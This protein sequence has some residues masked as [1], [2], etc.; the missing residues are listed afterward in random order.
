MKPIPLPITRRRFTV[1]RDDHGVPH[2]EAPT[3]LDALYGLGYMH[4]TDRGTQLLFSRTL[5]NGCGAEEI[6]DTPELLETDRFFRRVGLHLNL[7]REVRCLNDRVFQQIT[8]YCEGVTDGLRNSG[9]SLPM[10]A[11]GYQPQ[12]WNQQAVLLI[13]KLLSFGGLAISQMQNERLIIELVHAGANE[14]TIR[15]LLSP[16]FDNVDFDVLRQIKMSNQLSDDALEVL[17]DLPRLAGSNAWA[18]SP[19]RSATGSALLAADPHLEVNRLPGIWYEAVLKWDH[20]YLMGASLPGCP[21]FAVARTD[22]LAWGV[23]YMKGDTVDYFI[24][25]C[26]K[27]E[28]GWQYRRGT[29]WHDFDCREEP[30]ARKGADPDTLC[31]Y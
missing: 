28:S 12:P 13:G 26:R 27:A 30:I 25:D 3:W 11:T 18:V 29:T 14:A 31:V 16:R 17:T 15:E 24:E 4:A 21:L 20:G 23:T 6:A 2:V 19:Q 8:A 7:E 22:R 1:A 9:R 5:A 10:W